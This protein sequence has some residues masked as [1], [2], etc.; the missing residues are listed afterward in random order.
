M[1]H[2]LGLVPLAVVT[3]IVG[4]GG[5]P[6]Q[7]ASL[8]APSA[9]EQAQRDGIDV[10]GV[11]ETVRHHVGVRGPGRLYAEDA[12]YRAGFDSAGL[13]LELG[14]SRFRLD[15]VSVDGQRVTPAAW[16]PS[17]NTA[18]RQLV[19]G[20]TERITARSGRVEWDFVLAQPRG[21]NGL[22]IAASAPGAPVSQRNALRWSV[23]RGSHV[24]MSELAVKDA[25][26]T[27]ILRA[28]PVANGHRVDL[29]VPGRVLSRAAYP[30]TV[31][32]VVSPE[33]PTSDPVY[34][35]AVGDQMDPALATNGSS[36]LVVWEDERS[37]GEIYG[38]RVGSDGEVLDP[39]GIRI[40]PLQ[41]SANNPVVAWDGTNYFVAWDTYDQINGARV[42]PSGEVLDRPPIVISN[43][44]NGVTQPAVA[45]NG[46]NY[47]V[48][49]TDYRSQREKVFGA[50]VGSDGVV[51]DPAGIPISAH[52]MGQ[53]D[54][55]VASDG[56]NWFVAWTD[57]RTADDGVFATRVSGAGVVLDPTGIELSTALNTQYA[58]SAA[59]NGTTYLVA[60]QDTRLSWDPDIYASRVSSE[61]AVLDP[62]GIAVSTAENDQRLPAVARSGDRFVVVWQDDRHDWETDIYGARIDTDGTVLDPAGIAISLADDF[63]FQPSIA[64][65]GMLSLIAWQDD[66]NYWYEE[67]TDV[68]GARL[69]ADGTVQDADGIIL[70]TA[71]NIQEEPAIAWDGTNYFVVWT[72]RSSPGGV[73]HLR[74]ARHARRPAPR[75]HRNPDLDCRVRSGT[76]SRHLGRVGVPRRLARS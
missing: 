25:H 37:D 39:A 44:P 57:N 12:R 36:S 50:R 61:G 26:G 58:P 29:R 45:W 13:S 6:A 14:A 34:G 46:V 15:T 21:S 2:S 31:D 16:R 60:W 71:A 64:S 17:L 18:S 70:S 33:Y 41:Q 48:A 43:A 55:T 24:R 67:G 10:G 28:L 73:R 20:L 63:Q 72:G 56:E 76:A 51:L 4:G 5:S 42:T 40:S 69:D 3:A 30:V 23:G 59:W 7:P 47:L 66:R 22:V 8:A 19:P 54:P 27:E 38:A 53:E 62:G 65:W 1:R 68:V 32:P 9:L 75:R 52:S 49:W 74:R 35:A 11:I